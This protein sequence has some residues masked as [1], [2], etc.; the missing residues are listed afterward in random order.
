MYLHPFMEIILDEVNEYNL[1]EYLQFKMT[2][3]MYLGKLMGVNTFDQPHVE[4]YKVET[5]RVLKE[6]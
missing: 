3:I 6:S 2:E 1:G 5:K 4:L